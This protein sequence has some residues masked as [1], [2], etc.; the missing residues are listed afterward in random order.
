VP[1]QAVF[2]ARAVVAVITGVR[3]LSSVQPQVHRQVALVA[4][5]VV[6][7]ITGI[8]LL[9]SVHPQVRRQAALVVR[10][11]VAAI[12]GVRLLPTVQPQ[13]CCQCALPRE[14]RVAVLADVCRHLQ[15]EARSE[16]L[17]HL[18]NLT[19]AQAPAVMLAVQTF[20]ATMHAEPR[21]PGKRRT[22]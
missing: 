8:R 5:A 18:R 13:V 1:R 3:L 9:S 11:V 16:A 2:V 6:A 20:R 17:A 4:R 7:V 12:T 19:R 21:A 10:A 22:V 14:S 15:C